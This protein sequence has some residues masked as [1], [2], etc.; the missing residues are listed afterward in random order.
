MGLAPYGDLKYVQLIKDH[1]IDIKEDG[2]FHLDMS[3]FDYCTGLTMTN[4]KFADL[5]NGPARHP[6]SSLRQRDMDLAASIQAVTEEVIIK[7]AKDIRKSTEQKNLCLAGGVAL[8]CVANGKLAREKIFDK[9]WIQPASG[10]AGGA[11]G[12]ALAAYYLF[13]EQP[14][15]VQHGDDMKGSYLGPDYSQKDIERRLKSIG[16]KFS[17]ASE[18]ELIEQTALALADGKA[19]GWH[20]GRMEF[21]PRSLGNRSIIA[22]PRSPN[23]QKQLN[24]KIKY[25]ES[26]RPFAP[27]VLFDRVNEWF[28]LDTDSP[29]ML[30]VAD[31]QKKNEW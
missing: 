24:L 13:S 8:N 18:D 9:I 30:L 27:S 1:L 17:V 15:E 12:A 20:Q 29:Y 16:A 10:D 26:F 4:G 5:F 31:V 6:E 19:V 2:S 11:I 23:M 7:L 25:R 28:D 3:Y 22:D 14:R 21:G